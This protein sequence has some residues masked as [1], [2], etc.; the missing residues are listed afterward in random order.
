[1]GDFSTG[2]GGDWEV[3]YIRYDDSGAYAIPEPAS[4]GLL[5]LMGFIYLVKR[6]MVRC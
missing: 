6:R 5:G 4:L 1:L 3:D 2:I